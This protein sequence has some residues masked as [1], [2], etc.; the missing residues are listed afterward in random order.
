[1]TCLGEEYRLKV[2]ETRVL[3][4]TFGPKKGDVTG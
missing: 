1:M 3:R 4:R 2:L